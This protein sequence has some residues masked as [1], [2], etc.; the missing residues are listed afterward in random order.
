LAQIGKKCHFTRVLNDALATDVEEGG[1]DVFL[2][3]I[4]GFF[5]S[6]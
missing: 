3:N 2:D 6:E 4:P 5:Q 1:H